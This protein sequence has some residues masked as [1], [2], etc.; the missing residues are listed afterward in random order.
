M[1][2]TRIDWVDQQQKTLLFQLICV[3]TW[4][5]FYIGLDSVWDIIAQRDSE[6]NLIIDFS[7]SNTFPSGALINAY[8][9]TLRNPSN[10]GDIV[11]VT[12]SRFPH[13]VFQTL[14]RVSPWL[15]PSG[16][17][18]IH[19]ASTLQESLQL[20]TSPRLVPAAVLQ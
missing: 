7:P 4:D 18:I 5:D 11:I 10:V 1:M 14:K 20:L 16:N 9:A 6:I 12:E 17:S 19:F 8:R 3:W 2:T 13:C 15:V